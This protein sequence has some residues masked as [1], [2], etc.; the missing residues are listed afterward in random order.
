MLFQVQLRE[1]RDVIWCDSVES[2]PKMQDAKVWHKCGFVGI[3][4]DWHKGSFSQ[5]V[6]CEKESKEWILSQK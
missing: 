1:S 3:D 6:A 5:V 2:L 4:F